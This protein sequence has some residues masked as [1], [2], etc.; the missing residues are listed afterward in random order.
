MTRMVDEVD[1]DGASSPRN[2]VW[3]LEWVVSRFSI[4]PIPSIVMGSIKPGFLCCPDLYYTKE[5]RK[6]KS[7]ETGICIHFNCRYSSR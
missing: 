2:A 7:A 4:I 6:A 5:W 3:T 1:E